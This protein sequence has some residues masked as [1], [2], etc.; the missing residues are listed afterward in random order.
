M[1]D[2]IQLRRDTAANWAVVNPVLA[3]GEPGYALDTGVLK[4]GDGTSAWAS[5]DPISGGGSGSPPVVV[6]AAATRGSSL[7][8]AVTLPEGITSGDV[9]LLMIGSNYAVT[10][11]PAGWI[12]LSR[13]SATFHNVAVLAKLADGSESGTAPAA[14]IDGSSEPWNA[15]AV[16]VRG[17]TR[18][19]SPARVVQATGGTTREADLLIGVGDLGLAFGS[20]R[21]AASTLT[22]TPT[23]STGVSAD[24]GGGSNV[25]AVR[26]WTPDTVLHPSQVG[27]TSSVNT[28]GIAL[29]T[30]ALT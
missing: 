17:A 5:L 27:L 9:L 14:T 24:S 30:I 28:S 15:H 1:S 19:S 7:A 4:L 12:L 2:L 25:S 11:P 22:F 23:G 21:V 16:V 8:P 10:S 20:A 3:A 26:S 29:A 13:T 18:V 6:A